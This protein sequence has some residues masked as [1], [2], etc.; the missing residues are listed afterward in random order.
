MKIKQVAII[1]GGQDGAIFKNELF[2]FGSRGHCTV[3]DM[4][5]IDY[6]NV[7]EL[8]PIGKF[9]LDRSD[10]LAPHSNAVCFGK[11]YFSPDDEYPLL[12]SN[13]YNNYA[14]EE[15]KRIG[16]CCVYRL[17]RIGSEY[18]TTLVQ[19]IEIGFCS[20]FSLWRAYEDSDGVRPYGNFLVDCE[21]SS[22]YAFVMR[23]EESGTR[24]FRF[25]LPSVNEGQ[26]DSV[27]GVPKVVLCPSDVRE[28]FD[29]PPHR[30]VQGA[31]IHNGVIYSTEG[32]TNN[33][34][35]RP[36]IRLISTSAKRQEHYFDLLEMGF[37]N[38]A[39]MID[40]YEG[41]CYYSD[42]HGNL[43]LVDFEVSG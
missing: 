20:D 8:E 26:P 12:Y 42:V 28:Y 35:N 7:K 23:S 6:E 38:E 3:Y 2:R 10:V 37:A 22:Y 31:T 36:A 9:V 5:D 13:V 15:E 43:F 21:S 19:L 16:V 32:F 41:S 27:L 33:E 17:Q 29:C 30:Y 40:F 11:E 39:E 18:K 4:R 14:K 34:V 1:K 25:D 24:Y